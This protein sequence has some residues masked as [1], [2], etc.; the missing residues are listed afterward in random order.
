MKYQYILGLLITTLITY[1][2]LDIPILN[3]LI[4]EGQNNI[5]ITRILGVYQVLLSMECQ[6]ETGA[7][8]TNDKGES[9]RYYW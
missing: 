1:S 2:I 8:H 4:W 9:G 7:L 5:I 3:I 6:L